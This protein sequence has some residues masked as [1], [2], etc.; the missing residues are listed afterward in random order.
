MEILFEHMDRCIRRFPRFFSIDQ[1]PQFQSLEFKTLLKSTGIH[2]RPSGVESHSSLGTC[3]RYHAYFRGIITK[4]RD[5]VEN[6]KRDDALILAVKTVKD[7][8]GPIGLVPRLLVFGVMPRL[9]VHPK[10]IPDQRSRMHA[11][12]IA[13]NEMSRMMEKECVHVSILRNVPTSADADIK[14]RDEVLTFREK[15]INK[16]I[17]HTLCWMSME[18]LCMSTSM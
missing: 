1:G 14:I 7:T 17:G 5:Y 2:I 15:P 10:D 6:L 3:E 13:L 16:L 12:N 18:R 8:A 11:M 9:P 4:V